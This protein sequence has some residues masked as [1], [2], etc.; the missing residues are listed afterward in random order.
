MTTFLLTFAVSTLAGLLLTPVVR[1]WAIRLD[2]V[3]RPDTHRKMHA[4]VTPLGG[5]VAVFLAATFTVGLLYLV[6][7]PWQAKLIQSSWEV[8]GLWLGSFVLCCV[9]LFDDR[10]RL[11]GR[12][13]LLG[14][15]VAVSIPMAM[16]LT[17]EHIS[18]F[19]YP[20]ALGLLATPFTMF[21]LLGAIN[22]L[23]LLDGIDGLASSLGIILSLTIAA[24]AMLTG[25]FVA[26]TLSL[27]LAG[28]LLG[29]LR[30][31]FPPASIFL[32]DTG[33]MLIGLVVGVLA[34]QC[35]LKGPATVAL[36]APLAIWAIPILDSTAA[37]LRRKLTG[38]SI[39]ATDRGHLHHSLLTRGFSG[40]ATL[41][42]ISFFAGCTALGAFT[43]VYLQNEGFAFASVGAVLAILIST[44]MFGHVELMLVNHRLFHLAKSLVSTARTPKSEKANRI[45]QDFIRLQGS[46]EWEQLWDALTDT[47]ERLNLASVGL[48]L[49]APQ[50][51]EGY[52]ASWRRMRDFHAEELWRVEIPLVADG[53]SIGR[54]EITAERDNRSVCA[55]IAE[56]LDH[57]EPFEQ[58]VLGLLGFTA[59]GMVGSRDRLTPSPN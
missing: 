58:Q 27:A 14:Q 15:V 33:S 17:I 59:G 3:D 30:Y 31:N 34:I 12:Q 23:N 48:H 4:R 45:Q 44:R 26:A 46:R 29:F 53:R 1:S 25:N 42:W 19:G 51:H 43:S 18:F 55:S 32:G 54:L 35:S 13:K 36:S 49:N 6:P 10:Y 2:L 56:V 38:R 5:G 8:L 40:R 39:Y 37:I 7:N 20:I 41:G 52:Y 57:L 22:A 9:G 50:Q 28:G 11:R 21:W 16:G 47:A 24:L